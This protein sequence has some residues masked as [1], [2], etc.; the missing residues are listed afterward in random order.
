M[1]VG[2]VGG[3]GSLAFYRGPGRVTREV[4]DEG[5]ESGQH[6]WLLRPSLARIGGLRSENEGGGGGVERL[7]RTWVEV[8]LGGDE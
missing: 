1:G 4:V 5:G 2:V 8:T 7:E 6:L 3:G